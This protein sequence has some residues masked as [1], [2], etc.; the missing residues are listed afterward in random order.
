MEGAAEKAKSDRAMIWWGAMMPLMKKPPDYEKFTGYVPDK[1]EV[2][3]RFVEAWDKVE[4]GLRR[5]RKG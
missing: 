3:R 4:A 5:N 2:L 1:R